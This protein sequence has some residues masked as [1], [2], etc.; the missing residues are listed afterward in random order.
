MFLSIAYM[1]ID[2]HRIW[3]IV[4]QDIPPFEEHIRLLAAR[5]KKE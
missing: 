3:E 2:P 4:E 1:N 5:K